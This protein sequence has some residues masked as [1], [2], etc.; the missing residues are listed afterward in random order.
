MNKAAFVEARNIYIT[1]KKLFNTANRLQRES[2]RLFIKKHHL[3]HRNFKLYTVECD[4]FDEIL[5]QFNEEYPKAEWTYSRAFN[6]LKDA[7]INLAKKSVENTAN[8]PEKAK[9]MY[10]A[11]ENNPQVRKQLVELAL[12][13]DVETIQE[14]KRNSDNTEQ[15]FNS[16]GD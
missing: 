4:D 2:E 5:E 11:I 1:A 13:L 8:T 15:D 9:K 10:D 14:R 6:V 3:S 16:G 7:E 12:K